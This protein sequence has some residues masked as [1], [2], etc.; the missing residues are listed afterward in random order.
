MVLRFSEVLMVESSVKIGDETMKR[1]EGVTSASQQCGREADQ[2]KQ[3]GGDFCWQRATT[4]SR[5]PFLT[6]LDYHIIMVIVH[7]YPHFLGCN[8]TFDF[9][10]L[11]FLNF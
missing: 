7:H 2:D 3:E 10:D 11:G 6:T 9:F 5:V 4:M 1:R 8:V